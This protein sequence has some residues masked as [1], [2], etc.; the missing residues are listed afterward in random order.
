MGRSGE[1]TSVGGVSNSIIKRLHPGGWMCRQR[2]LSKRGRVMFYPVITVKVYNETPVF[3]PGLIMLLGYIKDTGSMK[4][5]CAEMAMSY[6]KGWKIVNRAEKALG[7]ELIVRQHGGTRGGNCEVTKEGLSLIQ[8]YCEME[9]EI[10]SLALT[11]FEQHFPEYK[12]G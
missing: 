7:Y 6:S 4:E 12:K 10:K 5:A 8:R 1:D 9:Q 11:A 3:G 2:I